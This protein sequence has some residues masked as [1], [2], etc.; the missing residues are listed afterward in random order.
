MI[1][2][3]SSEYTKFI[4]DFTQ[5]YLDIGIPD[6]RKVHTLFFHVKDFCT[7]THK[8]LGFYN[9]QARES[10]HFDF[11]MTWKK[12]KVASNNPDYEKQF[13]LHSTRLLVYAIRVLSSL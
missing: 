2:N 3:L 13:A 7:T 5:D 11:F 10:V 4:S 12:H 1:I 6:T 9:N 8:S